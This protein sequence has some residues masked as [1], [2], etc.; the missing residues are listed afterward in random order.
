MRL[1]NCMFCTFMYHKVHFSLERQCMAVEWK[2]WIIQSDVKDSWTP[3]YIA[4]EM[5]PKGWY[6][7]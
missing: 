2:K 1:Q 5:I 4:T 3:L 7:S 6:Q